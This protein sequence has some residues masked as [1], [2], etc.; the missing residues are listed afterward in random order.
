[1]RKA[2]QVILESGGDYKDYKT[3]DILWEE[4]ARAIHRELK[5]LKNKRERTYEKQR[6]EIEDLRVNLI[7]SYIVTLLLAIINILAI[8]SL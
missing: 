6:E 5:I 2:K 7:L 4:A 3:D 1:M 8:L